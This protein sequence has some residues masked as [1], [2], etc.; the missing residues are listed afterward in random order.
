MRFTKLSQVL[1]KFLIDAFQAFQP[2]PGGSPASLPSKDVPPS[3]NWLAGLQDVVDGW[4][5]SFS[6]AS[7]E[8]PGIIPIRL[9]IGPIFLTCCI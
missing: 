3:E 7:F 9:P 8:S 1:I 4:F 2:A 5:A 6:R